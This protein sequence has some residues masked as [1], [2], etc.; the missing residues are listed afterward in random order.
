MIK[1]FLIVPLLFLTPA[2]TF[3][4][5]PSIEVIPRGAQTSESLRKE[6]QA[7][8][9]GFQERGGEDI[10]IKVYALLNQISGSATVPYPSEIVKRHL[11][12]TKLK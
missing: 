6:V 11:D 4:V 5:E 12:S 2:L 8:V 9:D 1:N 10:K 3:A 7:V